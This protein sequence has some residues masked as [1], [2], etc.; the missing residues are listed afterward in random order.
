VRARRD[1]FSGGPG[2]ITL[3]AF[4]GLRA[5][6]P[7]GLDPVIL[8]Y[9]PVQVTNPYL[10]LLYRESWR[11]GIAPIGIPN[12]DGIEELAELA[13]LGHRVVLHMHW[14]NRPLGYSATEVD[15]ERDAAA[16]LE[17]LDRFHDAGGRVVWTVHN[18]LPH[19]ARYEAQEKRLR[20]EVAKRVD[21][22]HVMVSAT[23]DLVAPYFE[24]PRDRIL[25]VPH[26]NYLGAYPDF[27][28][29]EQARAD[30]ELAPDDLVYLLLGTIRAYKGLA[31]LL[32]AWAA[33]PV[34][35][36]ARRLVIAGGPGREDG[37]G[38]L[39]ERAALMPGVLVSGE[40][41]ETERM[42]VFLRAAD[43]AVLPYVRSLNSGALLLALSFDLPAVIPAEAGFGEVLDERTGRTFRPGDHDSLVAALVAAEEIATPASRMAARE[44]ARRYDS[45][46]ISLRFAQELRDRLGWPA[47][48]PVAPAREG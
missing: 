2:S 24:L 26:P 19:A 12:E 14:L 35:G 43:V 22:V 39:I 5:I 38:A 41:V 29:R 46:A 10:A 32:D 30:L 15:A 7:T 20:G 1:P 48:T 13:R 27:V 31:D 16:F 21:V 36:V 45:A 4:S 25:H 9:Y 11:A 47:G 28:S 42:Q 18:L 8:G 33:M 3:D 23:P 44:I 6:E 37:V 40:R 17:R 34:D